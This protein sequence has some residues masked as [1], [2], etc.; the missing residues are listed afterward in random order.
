MKTGDIQAIQEYF[1]QKAGVELVYLY[2]SQAKKTARED[3]DIDLAI[4]VDEKKADAFDTQIQASY[5]L[6]KQLHQEVE[7]Q[8]L[9]AVD[10]RFAH[11][12]LSQGKLL[13]ARSLEAKV[14]YETFILQQYFDLKPLYT[15]YF[16]HLAERART[17]SLGKGYELLQSYRINK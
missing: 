6:T 2:G 3:S 8:N 14:I 7:I 1:A 17:R 5:A 12:V 4:L 9:V 13:Y 11:T 16:T 10:V 15:E